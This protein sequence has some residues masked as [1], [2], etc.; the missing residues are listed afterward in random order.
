MGVPGGAMDS[1]LG[2]VGVAAVGGGALAAVGG[3][4][5]GV[6]GVAAGIGAA[7]G[8]IAGAYGTVAGKLIDGFFGTD[9][10]NETPP[11]NNIMNDSRSTT[12]VVNS[13]SNQYDIYRKTADDS[14]MLPNHRREYG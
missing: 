1:I 11:V 7:V 9:K 12:T 2:A 8:G 4:A 13:I 5:A 6:G 10:K 14:F 3:I